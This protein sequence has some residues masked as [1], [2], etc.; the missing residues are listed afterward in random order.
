M[1]KPPRPVAICVLNSE[2]SGWSEPW[3]R[4]LIAD[5]ATNLG[6]LVP[7]VIDLA[8]DSLEVLIVEIS[9]VAARAIIVP[10]LDH[11]TAAAVDSLRNA[12]LKIETAYPEVTPQELK[13]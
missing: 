4:G 1:T 8:H 5:R 13:N 6:Y 3:D 11:L 7:R 9:S 2:M 10:S 12:G